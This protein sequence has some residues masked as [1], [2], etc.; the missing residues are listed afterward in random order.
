MIKRQKRM[1]VLAMITVFIATALFLPGLVGAG[2]LEPPGPPE[3]TMHTLEQ[4][5]NNVN[6]QAEKIYNKP[7]WRVWGK[8]F[9]DW[10]DND[11]YAV[12][13][14]FYIP[15]NIIWGDMV[16]DKE[17]GLIW[18]RDANIAKTRGDDADGYMICLRQ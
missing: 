5:Y 13:V 12:S 10:P 3:S 8:V 14:D 15:P 6:I 16:L 7:R 1:M 4:I 11:R 18:A 17:T 9:A 2:D